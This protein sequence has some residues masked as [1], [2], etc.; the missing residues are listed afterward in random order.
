MAANN[1][2]KSASGFTTERLQNQILLTVR[3]YSKIVYKSTKFKIEI[4][5]R[6]QNIL[7]KLF[8]SILEKYSGLAISTCSKPQ[9]LF[10]LKSYITLI[11]MSS[12][13]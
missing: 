9:N 13:E 3:I 6:F 5:I 4:V 10:V 2:V 7:L 1:N 8:K 12:F 11:I